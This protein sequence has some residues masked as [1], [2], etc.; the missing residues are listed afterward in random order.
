MGA[1]ATPLA[2]GEI[3][4]A[5]QTGVVD[6]QENPIWNIAANKWNEVQKY[7]METRHLVSF[8][9]PA[10]GPRFTP[11]HGCRAGVRDARL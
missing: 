8:Y 1:A 10:L 2:S 3:Y 4:T 7:I 6:G 11:F 5:C 9:L